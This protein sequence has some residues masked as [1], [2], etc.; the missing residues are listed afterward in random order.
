MTRAVFALLLLVGPLTAQDLAAEARAAAR[1]A[2][3]FATGS[4]ACRGG[5][6][7]WYT[8]DLS[9]REG[10]GPATPTTVWV[11]EPGTPAVGLV[12][13]RLFDLTGDAA[14]LDAATETGLCLAW[15]QLASGGWDYR[16][17]FGL[18]LA[19]RY[20][21]RRELDAGDREPGRRRNLSVLD[22]DTTQLALRFLLELNERLDGAEPTIARA[23]R[24]GLEALLAAQYPSGG[25]A[26]VFDRPADP[27]TPVLQARYPESWSR[28]P[29]RNHDYWRF[30]TLNDNTLRDC[31]ETCL[32][33][34]RLT[35][36][37]RFRA[38]ALRGGEFLLRAQMPEPQPVWAQQYN[39]AME[40]IWA[41][42][43][44]PPSVTAGESAGALRMLLELWLETGEE[45][46]RAPLPAAL[47]WY[48]E[49]QIAPHRW[50]RFYELR[51]GRPLYFVKD[52]YELT[53][54]DGN[55]PTHYSF[56]ND[57]ASGTIRTIEETLARGREATLKARQR[58]P[59]WEQRRTE[60]AGPA[61]EAIA[62][63]DARGR[64]IE[65]DRIKVDRLL[66]RLGDLAD[67]LEADAQAAR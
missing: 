16:V 18:P 55:L 28:T 19:G 59:N 53:Y 10:E 25:W 1:R 50:A 7:W 60:R 39:F 44:E 49:N 11:Q 3:E 23:V 54:D 15:G 58:A 51:T 42:R 62:A 6:L 47:R 8:A 2:L 66:A 46:F 22:D 57:Y 29:P 35:G 52:T 64:W 37:E 41:R 30:Y 67:Y 36:E 9:Y 34:H 12:W 33:A 26:Q 21:Y 43:F 4:V 14:Y 40:P 17:E 65:D 5:Y 32:L 63:Q 38:A 31:I 24:H 13:L 56:Q 48:R 20:Y 45:R 61:R 27:A